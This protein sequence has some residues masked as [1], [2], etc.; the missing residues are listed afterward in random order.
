[1]TAHAQDGEGAL[2][3]TGAAFDDV[4]NRGGPVRV[5][6]WAPWC[7]PC[8]ALVPILDEIAKELLKARRRARSW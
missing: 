5:D 2:H 4:V 8:R 3:L 1:M 7:G 6:F